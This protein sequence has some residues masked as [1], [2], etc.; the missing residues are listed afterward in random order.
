MLTAVD[1]VLEDEPVAAFAGHFFV[2]PVRLVP[3]VMRD[4]AVGGVGGGE[5]AGTSVRMIESGG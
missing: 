2:D 1:N 3:V 5:L 4:N